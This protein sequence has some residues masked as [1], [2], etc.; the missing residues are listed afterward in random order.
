MRLRTTVLM[1]FAQILPA[2]MLLALLTGCAAT[3]P[4]APLHLFSDAQFA[5]PAA[6]P[7]P[8]EVFALSPDMIDYL[9]RHIARESKT[10]GV[11][12]AL[13]DAL[14]SKG[15]LKLEYD[16]ALTRNAAETFA[17]RS[18]NC[19]SLVIM[20]AAL[21]RQ[22]GLTAEFQ[23]VLTEQS[24]SR[25]GDLYFASG[26]VNLTLGKAAGEAQGYDSQGRMTVDFMP[27]K[28]AAQ[29]RIETLEE[30]TIVAMYFSNR[31]AETLAQD[32]L[33]D[34]YWWV[35]AAILQDPAFAGAYNT[36]GVVLRRHGQ[37]EAARR[38]F[39]FALERDPS[40]PLIMS[41]LALA[42]SALGRTQEAEA[43]RRQ[44]ALL[45]PVQPFFFF[46][47]GMHALQGGDARE[48]V[49]LFNREI[50]RDPAYHEF[51]FWLAEALARLGQGKQAERELGLAIETSTTLDQ[52]QQYTS[53]LEGLRAGR[54]R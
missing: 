34:A 30:R 16:A 38:A 14:Y 29:H 36:L 43:M 50:E 44:L 27:E 26:H 17:A 15:Q 21:A 5:P 51:H 19:L 6:A 25:V 48:A 9:D 42:L 45:Q 40:N 54:P 20:T 49:R 18:G 13:F 52:R 23:Q 10:K 31:A 12:R 47:K 33:D 7:D 37:P 2:L 11:R 35:R 1:L 46:H 3:P 41:N 24:W 39:E 22:L 53:R 8:A 28:E 4:P 32:R